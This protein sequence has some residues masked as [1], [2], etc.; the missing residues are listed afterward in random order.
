MKES[1]IIVKHFFERKKT[2]ICVVV[3][4]PQTIV[5]TRAFIFCSASFVFHYRLIKL[6]WNYVKAYVWPCVSL[7]KPEQLQACA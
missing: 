4:P 5:F 7:T 2:L 6:F 1:L 3:I